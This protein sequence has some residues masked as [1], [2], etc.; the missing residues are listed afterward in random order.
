MRVVKVTSLGCP[1]CII[2]DDI[3]DD[4][5]SDNDF[6]V[7][8]LDYDFDDISKY[9]IGNILPVFIFYNNDVEVGRIIGEKS[10]KNFLKI[11]EEFKE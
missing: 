3:F 8:S 9:N 2:M 7:V 1:S 11:V 10:K 4:V 5:N 6:D